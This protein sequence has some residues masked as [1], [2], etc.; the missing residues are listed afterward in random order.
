MKIAFSDVFGLGRGGHV[1]SLVYLNYAAMPCSARKRFTGS[2]AGSLDRATDRR[3][4]CLALG[5]PRQSL[6]VKRNHGL[7]WEIEAP[8]RHTARRDPIPIS[9]RPL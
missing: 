4:C 9:S 1:A 7:L 8:L 5:R 2:V 6:A 3:R